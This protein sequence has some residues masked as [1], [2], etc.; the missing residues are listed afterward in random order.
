MIQ[1]IRKERG[2][3]MITV[4]I[5]IIILLI[6]T[7]I[8][9]YNADD[10]VYIKNYNALKNDIELLKSK[11]S[12]YYNEYGTVPAKV[13]YTAFSDGIDSVFN[14]IELENK[15]DFYVLDLQVLDGLT[16]NYGKD[17]EKVKNLSSVDEYYSDLYIINSST[18]NIFL[19]GGV[20]FKDGDTVKYYYTD[21]EK[22]DENRVDFRYVDGIKIPDG[23]YYIGRDDNQNIVIS[24]NID[25]KVNLDDANQYHWIDS[26]EILEDAVLQEGQTL[27]QYKQSVSE[28]KGYFLNDKTKY[29]IYF[30]VKVSL[31][32]TD[33]TSPYLP[34][35]DSTI[36]EGTTLETGLVVM[37]SKDNEWVWIEVPKSIF[38]DE[39]YTEGQNVTSAEGEENLQ[40]I[41]KILQN[42]AKDY[43][44]DNWE[45]LYFDGCGIESEEEYNN[46][47]NKMLKSVFENGGFWIGRYEAGADDYVSNDDGAARDVVVQKNKFTYN[48]VNIAQAQSLSSTLSTN[49]SRTSSLMFGIQWDLVCKYIEAKNVTSE[50]GTLSDEYLL[51]HNCVEFGNYSNAGFDITTENAQQ[52]IGDETDYSIINQD[53][54]K[55]VDEAILLTTGASDRNKIM[56]IYDLGGNQFEITLEKSK[57]DDYPV[58]VRGGSYRDAGFFSSHDYTEYDIGYKQISFR[59]TIF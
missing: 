24:L 54:N 10:M 56:N 2:V 17:Y 20:E 35:E 7:G 3:T 47:K 23:Y 53:H 1:N 14:E 11:V 34:D 15:D 50:E 12:V 31:P 13:K 18:H 41:E 48:W 8:L 30:D 36:L 45:D 21:Y 57:L 25:D 58:T 39:E 29:V 33:D 9:V 22:P 19:N 4:T 6:I 51:T 28:N 52:S 46:L 16:L 59:P 5:A 27:G 32:E 55:N 38:T 49:P 40:N 44:Y 26:E 42:Y 43:R 37:D